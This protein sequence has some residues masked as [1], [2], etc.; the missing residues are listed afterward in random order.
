MP[1]LGLGGEA[2]AKCRECQP[3]Q[4]V[5]RASH[6]AADEHLHEGIEAASGALTRLAE[7]PG[8]R[9]NEER[10]ATSQAFLVDMDCPSPDVLVRWA[11]EWE[12]VAQ[13]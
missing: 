1:S 8:L 6:E 2:D 10:A 12:C 13:G 4:R 9:A 7:T 11:E 3:T 5:E